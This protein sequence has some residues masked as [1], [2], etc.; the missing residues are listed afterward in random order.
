MNSPKSSH[1]IFLPSA[2]QFDASSF[3]VFS[4]CPFGV[5][6]NPASC[7]LSSPQKGWIWCSLGTSSC[8]KFLTKLC[9]AGL[10][11]RGYHTSS[12]EFLQ[13]MLDG[14][15]NRRQWGFSEEKLR[16]RQLQ[17]GGRGE[18][19]GE[20]RV[21]WEEAAK[22][23]PSEFTAKFPLPRLSRRGPGPKAPQRSRDHV[24]KQSRPLQ[25]S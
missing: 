19:Q 1:L 3:G 11:Q 5:C 23:S 10:R 16:F 8:E 17:S 14:F 6:G 25:S 13:K 20:E 9:I 15:G 22:K 21:R 24:G 12:W 18:G 7:S 2:P 4:S